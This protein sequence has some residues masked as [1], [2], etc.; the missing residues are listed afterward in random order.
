MRIQI[1]TSADG[2]KTAA[3]FAL[4]ADL[5]GPYSTIIVPKNDVLTQAVPLAYFGFNIANSIG[6]TD[7]FHDSKRGTTVSFIA[8]TGKRDFEWSRTD[9][10]SIGHSLKDYFAE[11]PTALDLSELEKHPSMN[12][13]VPGDDGEQQLFDAFNRVVGKRVKSHGGSYVVVDDV[14]SKPETYGPMFRRKETGRELVTIPIA[15]YG[16]CGGCGL[17]GITFGQKTVDAV[18]HE[19]TRIGSSYVLDKIVKDPSVGKRGSVLIRRS[20]A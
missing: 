7:M 5:M 9:L 20:V 19:L 4:N 2:N 14:R 13:Y 1:A 15:P 3:T 12:P 8:F 17:F 18:N 6:R 16:A 10:Q 11:N